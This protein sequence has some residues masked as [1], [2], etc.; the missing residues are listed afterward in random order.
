MQT[1][2]PKT[3]GNDSGLAVTKLLAGGGLSVCIYDYKYYYTHSLRIESRLLPARRLSWSIYLDQEVCLMALCK[4]WNLR[5]D[6]AWIE[7]VK[8][9]AIEAGRSNPGA[10]IRDLVW[11]I[12]QN[13]TIKNRI[14]ESLQ[15]V[16]YGK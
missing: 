8:I 12:A 11:T 14:I 1:I 16:H 9:Q 10:Y 5:A 13:P 15:G 2:K 3:R 6:S 4:I 7:Q